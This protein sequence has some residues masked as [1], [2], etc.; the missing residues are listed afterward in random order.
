[1]LCFRREKESYSKPS[2]KVAAAASFD[3]VFVGTASY[4]FKDVLGSD[5]PY[6]I[7][8][9][10]INSKKIKQLLD[11]VE[12]TYKTDVWDYAVQKMKD[13]KKESHIDAISQR[14]NQHIANVYN[15]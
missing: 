12:N 14:L 5:Y 11:K 8:Y 15:Q 7:P 13:V 2:T 9:T 3:T 1:M 10:G 4:A 6:M